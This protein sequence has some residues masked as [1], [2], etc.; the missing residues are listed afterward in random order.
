MARLKAWQ[1]LKS[2]LNKIRN[3]FIIGFTT[4]FA[5]HYKKH[6]ISERQSQIDS[7]LSVNFWPQPRY[8]TM[9]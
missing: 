2:P 3:R 9:N 1:T 5:A 6:K 7:K 8:P 4:N